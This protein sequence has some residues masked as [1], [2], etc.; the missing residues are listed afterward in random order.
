M[1]CSHL[2]YL[3]QRSIGLFYGSAYAC[4]QWDERSSQQTVK[5]FLESESDA[6][7]TTHLNRRSFDGVRAIRNIGM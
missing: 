7:N 6:P 2:E 4:E 1:F 5:H 3:S